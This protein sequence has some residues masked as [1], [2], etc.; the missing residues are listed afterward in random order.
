MRSNYKRLGGYIRQVGTRN[1]DLRV[2]DL[3]GISIN[4]EFMPSVANVIGTDLSVYR[5]VSRNQFAF[6]PMHVGR[7]EVLP[8]NL[9][10]NKDEVIVSPAYI[11]FEILDT[12]E[13]NPEYLMMWFRRFEFDRNVWFTT[14]SSVRWWLNWED[15]CNMQLPIPKIEKQKEI[16]KEYEV[17]TNRTNLNNTLIQKL[18]G[19]AQALHKEWFVDFEFPDENGNPYKSS[20]GEMEFFTEQKKEVPKGWNYEKI[21]NFSKEII[22]WKTPSTDDISNF[23]WDIPFLTIPDM[24]N[25][26]YVFSTERY[27]SNKWVLKNKVLP[28][29]SI[30]VSC[31]GTAWLVVINSTPSQTNQQINSIIPKNS[32]YLFW[33]FLSIKLLEKKIKEWWWKGSVWIN[34]NK[35]EFSDLEILFPKDK[36][37]KPFHETIKWVFD[38]TKNYEK[39]N[40]HL[41][42][43]KD[44]ILAKMASV[45]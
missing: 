18:E 4:K 21:D 39:E 38:N 12:N 5:V 36:L 41:W 2:T 10:N 15:F 6:N 33:L 40:E 37:L 35:S 1:T 8:I 11:V 19:T 31:I 29:D 44:L 24:H 9:L 26:T 16:V 20:G 45:V 28:V 14:D 43:M 17:L 30:C 23:N 13:L 25:K 32:F 3:Q 22:T 27:L 34:M 42:K 7:D